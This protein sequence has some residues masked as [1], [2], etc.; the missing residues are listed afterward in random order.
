LKVELG[1]PFAKVTAPN[2][3]HKRGLSRASRTPN[4]QRPR[5]VSVDPGL[6]GFAELSSHKGHCTT[7]PRL[8]QRITQN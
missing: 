2:G 1:K 5:I 8:M 6:D 3:F 7:F 4:E